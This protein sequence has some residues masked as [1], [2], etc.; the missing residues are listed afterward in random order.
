MDIVLDGDELILVDSVFEDILGG[1]NEL[2][3]QY[4]E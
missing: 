2:D 3:N 4:I 1:T